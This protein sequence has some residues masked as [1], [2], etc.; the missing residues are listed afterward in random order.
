M[1]AGGSVEGG[2]VQAD[3]WDIKDA[4][5]ESWKLV[6]VYLFP[7]EGQR[8]SNWWSRLREFANGSLSTKRKDYRLISA[9]V[10]TERQ[11]HREEE[12]EDEVTRAEE[13]TAPAAGQE[14]QPPR[15]RK[16]GVE[17]PAGEAAG[18]TAEHGDD[19][20]AN[21]EAKKRRLEVPREEASG[22]GGRVEKEG[23]EAADEEDWMPP[24]SWVDEDVDGWHE[25]GQMPDEK[26]EEQEV[27]EEEEEEEEED[28]PLVVRICDVGRAW[29]L[30]ALN[31]GGTGV[32]RAVN[33]Q[34]LRSRCS[35][36]LFVRRARQLQRSLLGYGEV[37]EDF[38]LAR[39]ADVRVATRV[40][41][42]LEERGCSG[43]MRFQ[44]QTA[45]LR[46]LGYLQRHCGWV[47]V[48]NQ[49]IDLLVETR[50]VSAA[51]RK[52][53]GRRG[54]LRTVAELVEMKRWLPAD[55]RTELEAKLE[56]R[57]RAAVAN[58]PVTWDDRMEFQ[59]LLITWVHACRGHSSQRIM[60]PSKPPYRLGSFPILT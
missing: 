17:A 31:V 15:A 19:G 14:E 52:R 12:T 29:R 21:V 24:D 60:R 9:A 7:D 42:A 38:D 1:P 57:L 53:E 10:A 11:R 55:K 45:Y 4:R 26:T 49:V 6:G 13:Q 54:R 40:C 34:P 23:E 18:D 25:D 5:Q 3:L 8:P 20:G 22:E 46:C 56:E 39:L 36:G 35:Q 51:D 59:D 43:G 37:A 48:S 58:P 16:R 33:L 32:N 44:L 2:S 30:R 28:G 50:A 27:V 41:E 47:S